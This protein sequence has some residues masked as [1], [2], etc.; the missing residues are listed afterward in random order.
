[1]KQREAGEKDVAC[2]AV[3]KLSGDP[4]AEYLVSVSVESQFR[5]ARGAAGVEHGCNLP[6]PDLAV[7]D[8]SGCIEVGENFVVR[9]HIFLNSLPSAHPKHG[10][11]GRDLVEN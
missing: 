4:R 6:R 1:M 9:N 3:K 7:A 2:P 8:Q 5:H 11:Q 10:L